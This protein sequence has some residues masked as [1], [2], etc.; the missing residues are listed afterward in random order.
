MHYA[1][2]IPM[3][4]TGSANF[5]RATTIMANNVSNNGKVALNGNNLEGMQS[6]AISVSVPVTIRPT[7][8]YYR[9][10][11]L[12]YTNHLHNH[13][14]TDH[15]DHP[16]GS[17]SPHALIRVVLLLFGLRVDVLVDLTVARTS[18]T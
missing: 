12:S 9:K 2:Q 16:V 13:N 10:P 8:T 7:V 11:D 3:R 14:L 18:T 1:L 17:T 15:P 5:L 4:T 6:F